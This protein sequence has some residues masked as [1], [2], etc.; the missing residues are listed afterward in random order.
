MVSLDL[1]AYVLHH[2]IMPKGAY[3]IDRNNKLPP[4]PR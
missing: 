3:G 1:Y 4:L 2:L